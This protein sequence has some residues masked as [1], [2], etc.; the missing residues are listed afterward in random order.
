MTSWLLSILIALTLFSP[1]FAGGAQQPNMSGRV[2]GNG[3]VVLEDKKYVDT[4]LEQIRKSQSK[5]LISMYIFKTT[6]N[7]TSAANKV[8]DALI[9]AAKRGV[10]V[11]VVLEVEGGTG[12][13]LN[14]ENRITA[15]KLKNGGVKVYFDSP[16][17]RTHVKAI[18]IDDRY[19]FIGSHNLTASALQYN[20]ELSIMI[21]SVEVAGETA[22]YIE[23]MLDRNRH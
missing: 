15:K 9:K 1:V 7:K 19:T 22:G 11:K 2:D 20:K 14:E 16:R 4:L 13:T 10:I 18:V 5:I 3:I 17:R 6:G 8:K 12:S 23:E 21:D